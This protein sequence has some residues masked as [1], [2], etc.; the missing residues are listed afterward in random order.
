[1]LQAG[2]LGTEKGDIAEFMN[3]SAASSFV[4]KRRVPGGIP[5]ESR[6]RVCLRG[7]Q[8]RGWYLSSSVVP[9]SSKAMIRQ[10]LERVTYF[11]LMAFVYLLR[12]FFQ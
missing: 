4:P 10:D 2:A 6:I 5:N 8:R 3:N 11:C 12:P 7:T 1:M 9:C